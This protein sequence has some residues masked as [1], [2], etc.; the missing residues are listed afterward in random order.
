MFVLLAHAH[1][2]RLPKGL[3]QV[4]FSE[5]YPTACATGRRPDLNVR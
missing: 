4:A 1:A 3:V 5:K 2:N